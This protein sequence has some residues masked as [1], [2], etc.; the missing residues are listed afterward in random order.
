MHHPPPRYIY[1]KGGG[2]ADTAICASTTSCTP[3]E[4]KIICIKNQLPICRV[5]ALKRETGEECS[6]TE[7]VA[8]GS[9][10]RESWELA[11]EGT[12]SWRAY[13]WGARTSFAV[14]TRGRGR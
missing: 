6:E 12:S 5:F 9:R 14:R 4:M 7:A 2:L 10:S 8:F 11:A 1:I 3:P 13:S